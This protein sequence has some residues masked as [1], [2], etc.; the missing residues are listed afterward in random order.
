MLKLELIQGGK[1]ETKMICYKDMVHKLAH[2][3]NETPYAVNVYIRAFQLKKR[4]PHSRDLLNEGW[5]WDE[6][7]AEFKGELSLSLNPRLKL[8]A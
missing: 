5:T 2:Y 8:V 6:I 1:S 7:Y 3:F 4:V